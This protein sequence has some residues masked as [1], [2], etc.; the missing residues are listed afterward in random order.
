MP[1]GALQAAG[2]RT[3]RFPAMSNAE[4]WSRYL[5]AHADRRT[6][7]LHYLGTI[8]AA[9]FLVLAASLA[10]WRWLVAAP[11]V[12]YG[13]AWLGHAVFE[14]NRPE[15]FSHPAWS[16]LSDIRMLGLFLTGRLAG[17]LQRR[18]VERPADREGAC[19]RFR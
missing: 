16:L 9:A 17:E 11:L 6:R 15:T 4:F 14:H 19:R 10:D 7:M 5:A 13:P 2:R 12:G 3:A 1:P 18:E 8:A